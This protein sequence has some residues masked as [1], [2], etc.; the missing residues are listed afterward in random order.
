MPDEIITQE[1]QEPEKTPEEI[2]VEMKSKMVPKEELQYW[3][4]KYNKLFG[5]VAA[6][7]EAEI[8]GTPT[9]PEEREKKVKEKING[10]DSHEIK[11]PVESVRALLEIDDHY[12]KT[13]KRSIFEPSSNPSD[14]TRQSAQRVRDLLEYALDKAGDSDEVLCATLGSKLADQN[15]R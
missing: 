5:A 6:G 11:R 7:K 13:G 3:K 9:T 10:I 2:L 14:E 8:I 12:V 15:Y 4:E 1:G